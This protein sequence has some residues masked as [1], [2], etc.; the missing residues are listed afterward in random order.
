MDSK[1]NIKIKKNYNIIK[2]NLYLIFKHN[3]MNIKLKDELQ[4]HFEIN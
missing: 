1:I 3:S 4:L 2:I